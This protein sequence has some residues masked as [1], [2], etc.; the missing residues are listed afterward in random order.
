MRELKWAVNELRPFMGLQ[1]IRLGCIVGIGLV[2]LLDPLILKWIIDDILPAGRSRLLLIAAAGFFLVIL[3]RLSLSGWGASVN[4]FGAQRLALNIR[5][6]LLRHL[7]KQSAAYF[8][9]H[10]PGDL[11]YR[12]TSDVESIRNLGADLFSTA[13]SIL[14]TSG[15]SL[16]IMFLLSWKLALLVLPLIPIFVWFRKY[17]APRLSRYADELQRKAGDENGF[18]QESLT[19][20]CQLQLLN[21]E[22]GMLRR[23]LH[24]ARGRLAS[25]IK[26]RRAEISLYLAS[27]LVLGVAMVLVLAI[28]GNMVL[29]DSFTIGGLVAFN[30]YLS[31]LFEPLENVVDVYADFQR[32]AASIRR[33][34][35]VLDT[36][37]SIVDRP[38]RAA[39]L[40]ERPWMLVAQDIDFAYHR[41]RAILHNLS[42]HI[43]P[44]EMVA[45]AGHSGGGKSTLARLIT[46]QYEPDRGRILLGGVDIRDIPLK[47]LRSLVCLICQD[48][49]LFDLGFRENLLL[50]CPGAGEEEIREALRITNLEDLP[51][52]LA[53]GW[54][55]RLG[56]RASNLSGGQGK[57]LAMARGLLAKPR[58]LI[59]D[60]TTSALD[61]RTENLILERLRAYIPA[62]AILIIAHR[63]STLQQA[64]RVL[65]LHQGSIAAE[66][67][68]ERLYHQNE[69]YRRL[70]NRPG[71]G[72]A[73]PFSVFDMENPS[74]RVSVV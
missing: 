12:I 50:G 68:H 51:L 66:A 18:L 23:Y 8:S 70:C 48:S 25:G 2:S 38:G 63:I 20:M 32:S 71:P 34:L 17:A 58:L 46:R 74:S 37:P 35:Q 28:G 9:R 60:E 24:L 40:M 54:D 15:F 45:I 3:I 10:G 42:F 26:Q 22:K 64:D 61:G 43:E 5:L 30:A 11:H 65:L 7:Q 4:Y 56:P 52:S 16:V 59:L 27:S 29:A 1:L 62:T 69:L 44:G 6:K 67:S 47:Q 21:A 55:T 49:Q 53:A 19:A 57:R 31:R 72:T 13:I 41:D 14:I 39:A 33:V 36:E 73:S